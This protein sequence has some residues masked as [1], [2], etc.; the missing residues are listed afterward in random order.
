LIFERRQKKCP[1]K[2]GHHSKQGQIFEVP[3]SPTVKC[4]LIGENKRRE[5][6]SL[7]F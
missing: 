1:A 7:I 4:G 2:N 3:K 6:K 5:I